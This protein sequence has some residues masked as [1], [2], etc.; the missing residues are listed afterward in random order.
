MFKKIA[1]VGVFALTSVVSL[2]S[3]SVKAAKRVPSAA[4]M[5]SPIVNGIC[6]MVGCY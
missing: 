1:L 2:G 5:G 4:T 6:P 3:G